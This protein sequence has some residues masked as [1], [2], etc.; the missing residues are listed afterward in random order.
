MQQSSQ[1]IITFDILRLR[2]YDAWVVC[3]ATDAGN[4]LLNCHR[5]KAQL[6]YVASAC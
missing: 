2:L 6:P 1:Y 5:V 4:T 3:T